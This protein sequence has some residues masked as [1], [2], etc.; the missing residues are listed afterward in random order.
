M[1]DEFVDVV[2]GD[3]EET[4]ILF[5]VISKIVGLEVKEDS[6]SGTGLAEEVVNG[7]VDECTLGEFE[8]GVDC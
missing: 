7:A 4:V 8:D 3:A 6:V 5:F 1:K 2:E